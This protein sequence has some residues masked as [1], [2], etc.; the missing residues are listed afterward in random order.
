MHRQVD[1]GPDESE[2]FATIVSIIAHCERDAGI[3]IL[4]N[5]E[6]FDS[7]PFGLSIGS[8]D[9]QNYRTKHTIHK[10][11]AGDDNNESARALIAVACNIIVPDYKKSTRSCSY[12]RIFDEDTHCYF[13][14]GCEHSG[15]FLVGIDV[16]R[17]R[18][19]HHLATLTD[20]FELVL[21]RAWRVSVMRTSVRM[22]HKRIVESHKVT[23]LRQRM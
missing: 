9:A 15:V 18:H 5:A 11:T 13:E 21:A 16:R 19:Q 6:T 17:A 23:R 3:A 2:R 8:I 4:D 22:A 14:A 1:E 10:L 12:L 7:H 20:L